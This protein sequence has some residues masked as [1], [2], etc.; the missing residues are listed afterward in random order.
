MDKNADHVVEQ[1]LGTAS[2]HAERSG[3]PFVTLSYAQSLDGS[4]TGRPGEALALSGS[5]SLKLTHLL[6]ANHDAILVGIGTVLSDDPQLS[7][8]YVHGQSPQPVIL[9]GRL[10]LPVSSKLLRNGSRPPWIYAREQVDEQRRDKLVKSGAQL[11]S[12]PTDPDELLCLRSLLRKLAE[13]NIRSVMIEGGALV[14]TSFL[15]AGLANYTVLTIVPMFV[16]G[17]RALGDLRRTDP[18]SCLRV[19]QP[20]SAQ[21]GDDMIVWGP[22]SP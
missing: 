16:G 17:L 9:D 10:R 4:L 18:G 21:F 22:L 14:I 11:H 7:V 1:L 8:R 20:R 15:R 12:L 3:L 6:R 19:Q 2:G 13:Q 5:G